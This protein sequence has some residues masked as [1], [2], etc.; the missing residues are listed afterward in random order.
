[1]TR[2]FF[3]FGIA[4]VAVAFSSLRIASTRRVP[5]YNAASAGRCADRATGSERRRR[6]SGGRFGTEHLGEF[7]GLQ[8]WPGC[9]RGR[10][11]LHT[12]RQPLIARLV[13]RG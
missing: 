11:R 3:L 10:L 12:S 1:M 2:S 4:V 5:R 8:T 7:P 6:R 9:L 13:S